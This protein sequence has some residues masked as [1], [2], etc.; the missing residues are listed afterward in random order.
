MSKLPLLILAFSALASQAASAAPE[1]SAG[2]SDLSAPD[3][4]TWLE[5][6]D[7]AATDWAAR[8]TAS[9]MDRLRA[10]PLFPAIRDEMRA[11]LAKSS[12]PPSFYPLGNK[13]MRFDRTAEKPLG[14]LAIATVTNGKAGPWRDVLDV[15]AYNKA[16]GTNFQITFLS[17][18]E[19][20]LAPRFE[21]CLIPFADGGS[22]LVQYRE[23]DLAAGQFVEGGFETPPIRAGVAWLDE[24]RL[25][26]GHAL[27]DIPAL[28][29]GFAGG[30]YIWRRGTPL[31]ASDLIFRAN[32]GDSLIST[33]PLPGYDAGSLL[34]SLARDYQ[35]FEVNL[36]DKK[37]V[38]RPLDLPTSLQKF[39]APIVS[40]RYL[41]FLLGRPATIEGRAYAANSLIAY[42]P[43]APDGKRV[44][45]VASPTG[46]AVINDA[47]GGLAATKDAIAFVETRDLRK[48]L[49]LARRGQD[50][51]WIRTDAMQ[52]EP[53]VSLSIQ[54]TGFENDVLIKQAGF[55]HPTEVD[56]VSADGRSS[57]IYQAA[58]VIDASAYV[59][60]I[61][62]ARSKDGTTVDYYLVRPKNGSR[63]SAVI[64]A[65]YGGYGVNYDPNYFSGG[66]GLGLV[67]WLERGGAYALAAIRGGGERGSAWA[68]AA[69]GTN[70]QRSYD[71]FAAVAEDL[72]AKSLTEK[73]RIGVFGRSFGG[74]L[75]AN[76][77]VQ[78]PDLFNAALVGVP[79]V[80][81][82]RL[83]RDGKDI[84]AGQKVEVGD[85]DD[86]AQAAIMRAYSPYQ[87]ILPG[88]TY[89]RTLTVISAKDGQVGPG[90][91]R[92]F[93]AKL[94]SVGADAEL[95]EGPTGGHGFPDQLANP[96][97]FAAQIA[98][99]TDA[100]MKPR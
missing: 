38:I 93:V 35:T 100:L 46:G 79:I 81:L 78:R 4:F 33:T 50:G 61:R 7:K 5:D 87:N 84:S 17:P 45:L 74:L 68:D 66:L 44:S 41:A 60:E 65:G 71:D 96:E 43:A 26:L 91:G 59:S 29:S 42:D 83:G 6:S 76:M 94:Q 48:T 82:F 32:S 2:Q 69:R 16:R 64:I 52:A 86:P 10:V 97:E 30:L 55:L 77:A 98:F 88:R 63:P 28:K 20:C 34:I 53:G 70:R 99:F 73:G 58:P 37:G 24:N 19:Q 3:E 85:W 95:I 67:P 80:D 39:G 56:L 49:V 9:T 18:E 11:A 51:Q 21:R 57:Q 23:F 92:K 36:L 8:Q 90:H 54:G 72:L 12:P 25:A 62:T 13:L 40:G 15:S 22:S 27:A 47:Y 14:I 1:A 89:P 75:A 31:A